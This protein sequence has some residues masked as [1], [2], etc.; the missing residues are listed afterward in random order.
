[1]VTGGNSVAFVNYILLVYKYNYA[2][3]MYMKTYDIL[4]KIKKLTMLVGAIKSDC[5]E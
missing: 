2:M 3:Y 5:S 1:M 4:V